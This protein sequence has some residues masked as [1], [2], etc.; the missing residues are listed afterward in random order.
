MRPRGNKWQPDAGQQSTLFGAP[1]A[2]QDRARIANG[3]AEGK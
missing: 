1:P 2:S 3:L